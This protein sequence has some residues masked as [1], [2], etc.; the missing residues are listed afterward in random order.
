MITISINEAAAKYGGNNL[1]QV[2]E[3]MVASGDFFKIWLYANAHGGN[4]THTDFLCVSKTDDVQQVTR[5]L[6]SRDVANDTRI[7]YE[8]KLVAELDSEDV[9]KP[10]VI[11]IA[12]QT[13]KYNGNESHAL[14]QSKSNKLEWFFAKSNSKH[15]SQVVITLPPE[16]EILPKVENLVSDSGFMH[17]NW[18][19]TVLFM[20]GTTPEAQG[21]IVFAKASGIIEMLKK[22]PAS[23]TFAFYRL[24]RGGIFQLFV[25]VDTPE[26]RAKVNNS[27]FLAEHSRWLDE[28]EDCKLIEALI[29]RNKLEICFVA[30]GN[31]GPCTGYY[32]MQVSVPEKLKDTLRREWNELL[33]Y[34]NGVSNRNY[35]AALD[36]YN[37]EN[38]MEG[39][40]VISISQI[41]SRFT[42]ELE[43]ALSKEILY[44]LEPI[45]GDNLAKELASILAP[46]D[47]FDIAEQLYNK[48]GDRM[49][50]D[51]SI[52]DIAAKTANFFKRDFE[53]AIILYASKLEASVESSEYIKDQLVERLEKQEPRFCGNI[54]SQISAAIILQ[55]KKHNQLKAPKINHVLQKQNSP[56]SVSRKYWWEFWK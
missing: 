55:A 22:H 31:K 34:H 39:T 32:G 40:P 21:P 25:Q 33:T 3:N 36:Q 11:D 4:R 1:K 16:A 54:A 9:N 45:F 20:P 48:L 38:P 28:N 17:A 50:T 18:A 49:E 53:E 2:I 15:V 43:N 12:F 29:N 27:P 14:G 13:P 24:D 26:I 23:V 8:D 46:R 51:V 44:S 30:S 41:K 7:Y 5:F 47:A 37:R 6:M 52:H 35:Q 19:A 10:L 42:S 56:N